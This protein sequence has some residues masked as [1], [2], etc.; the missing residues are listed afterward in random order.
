MLRIC[1]RYVL[2]TGKVVVG[3]MHCTSSNVYFFFSSSLCNLRGAQLL[4]STDTFYRRVNY[5]LKYT[6]SETHE[7]DRKSNWWIGLGLFRQKEVVRFSIS[8]WTH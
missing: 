4:Q 8:G 2:L 1:L 3:F 7:I 6:S 5:L